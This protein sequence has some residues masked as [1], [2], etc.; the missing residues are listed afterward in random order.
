MPEHWVKL[1]G[2]DGEVNN[3]VWGVPTAAGGIEE[4]ADWF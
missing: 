2:P 1:M 3:G 4:Y